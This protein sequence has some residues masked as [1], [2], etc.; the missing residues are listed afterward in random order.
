MGER[1]KELD[2]IRV[3]ACMGVVVIHVAGYGMEIK[4]PYTADWM[5]RNLIVSLVRC[6]VPIFFMISGILFIEKE[7][8]ISVLY[9]KYVARIMVAWLT[10]S[11]LYALIDYVAYKREH[12]DAI[13]YF[14]LRFLSGHY[15]LWFLPALLIAYVCLPVLQ[16]IVKTLNKSELKYICCIVGIIILFK[17]TLNPVISNVF[18][19]AAGK[20]FIG[21]EIPVGLLYFLLGYYL[22]HY[23][24]HFSTSKCFTVYFCS[25]VAAAGVNALFSLYFN[26]HKSMT[27]GY[28]S[29]WVVTASAAL[30]IALVNGIDTEKMQSLDT[31]WLK[32]IVDNTFGIYLIHTFFIEQVYRRVGL[33]QDRFPVIISVLLFSVITFL[34]SYIAVKCIKKIPVI[35][36]W[37][38]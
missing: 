20:N 33:T 8:K 30:F 25:C 38:V 23:R 37:I 21:I 24:K 18:W 7:I 28:L 10:W 26:Q 19:N 36:E 13:A 6:S 16:K 1:K 27:S 17:E 35:G 12:K 32:S 9:K 34:I 5:I 15:H 22:Y 4:D 2:V 31:K 14:G 29:I 3:M 11:I